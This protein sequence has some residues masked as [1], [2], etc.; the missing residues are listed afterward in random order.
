[1]LDKKTQKERQ[2]SF[3]SLPVAI[4]ESMSEEETHAFLYEEEWP[5]SL[6]KKLDEFI[7]RE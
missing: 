3:E 5:E 2:E 1:M 6:F 7:L 4:K